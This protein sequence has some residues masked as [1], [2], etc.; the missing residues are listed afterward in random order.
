MRQ[1]LHAT[2]CKH[3]RFQDLP[4][5]ATIQPQC[6]A[7][8]MITPLLPIPYL[9][10]IVFWATAHV[11]LFEATTAMH[12]SIRLRKLNWE[13]ERERE[14]STF[15]FSVCIS[16]YIG[17]IYA[18]YYPILLPRSEVMQSNPL[19]EEESE[20]ALQRLLL[21]CSTSTHLEWDG[22]KRAFVVV[23]VCFQ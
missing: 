15:F 20:K 13:R 10:L 19:E 7:K 6:E 5:A 18:V 4:K 23:V 21:L 8:S 22:W 11:E 9:H 1:Y 3:S 16:Y 12:F 14:L 17:Y 2:I